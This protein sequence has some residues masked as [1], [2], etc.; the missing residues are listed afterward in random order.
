MTL[1]IVDEIEMHSMPKGINLRCDSCGAKFIANPDVGKGGGHQAESKLR[2][3][4]SA[5]GWTGPMT[6]GSATDKCEICTGATEDTMKYSL[7]DEIAKVQIDLKIPQ[8]GD[9]KPYEMYVSRCLLT[10][11][12]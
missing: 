4:A 1:A 10:R 6:R 8:L 9:D 12:E 3:Q 5:A 2:L 11:L 7:D